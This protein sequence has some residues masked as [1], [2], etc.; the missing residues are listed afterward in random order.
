MEARGQG[1]YAANRTTMLEEIARATRETRAE[2]GRAM[3]GVHVM[4]ALGRVTRESFV[5]SSEEAFAYQ[6][7]PLSIG[8]GQ[9]I[10]QPFIVALMTEL[11]DVKP[12][13]N[14]LEIGTGS[15]YQAAILAELGA[16]VRSIEIIEALGREAAERLAGLGY[17]SV[18]VRIADGYA[19]WPE[20]APYDGIIVTAAPADVPSPLAEQLKPGGKLVVPLGA[21]EGAQTLYVMEK[22]SDGTLNRQAV[23]AV[24]FVPLTG[25]GIH[26][27]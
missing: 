18:I 20:Y 26:A 24:R 17:D 6:N 16:R 19:G 9:T 7:S 13:D 23:L 27:Q 4:G 11:L 10:S 25:N 21:R 12:G 14:V 22:Q 3:L 2:T 5:P 15:G 8:L 1:Q